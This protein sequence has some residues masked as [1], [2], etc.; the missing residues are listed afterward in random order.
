MENTENK[1]EKKVIKKSEILS[2]R[3]SGKTKKEIAEHYDLPVTRM[4]EVFN[5]LNIKGR[6]KAKPSIELIVEDDTVGSSEEYS[7]DPAVIL[8]ELKENHNQ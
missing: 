5:Q 3:D 8:A 4:T 1:V 6:P 7:T 2:M